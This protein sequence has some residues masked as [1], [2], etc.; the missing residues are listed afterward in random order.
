[1][2][3]WDGACSEDRRVHAGGIHPDNNIASWTCGQ[4]VNI[5]LYTGFR[6]VLLPLVWHRKVKFVGDPVRDAAT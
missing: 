4:F 5:S 2:N 6:V 1:M 3:A